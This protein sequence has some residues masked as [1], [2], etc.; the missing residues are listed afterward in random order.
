MVAGGVGCRGGGLMGVTTRVGLGATARLGDGATAPDRQLGEGAEDSG[1]D[2][3]AGSGVWLEVR[4]G[5]AGVI[6]YRIL[7]I[8]LF[9][10][11][12]IIILL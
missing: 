3:T 1:E 4:G 7:Y 6:L 8:I 10:Y 12:Y 9:L 11:Y 5:Q 2:R